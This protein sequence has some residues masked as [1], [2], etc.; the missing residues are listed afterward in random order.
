M[1]LRSDF[2]YGA[3]SGLSNELQE[4]LRSRRPANIAQASR[5]PGVTPAALS[6]L[7]VYAKRDRDEHAHA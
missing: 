3:I 7:L 1:P 2:D 4:K 5:V 6:L